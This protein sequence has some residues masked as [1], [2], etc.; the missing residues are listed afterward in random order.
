MMGDMTRKRQQHGF[1]LTETLMAVGTLAIGMTFISGTF[2]AGIYFATLSTERT[3]AAVAAEEGFAKM[4][5]FGLDVADPNLKTAGFVLYDDLAT[6]PAN[7]SLYPSTRADTARQYSWAAICRRVADGNDVVDGNEVA[8]SR[9]LVQCVVFVNRETGGN[10]TYHKRRTG[11][12]GP[13]LETSDLP[14][15]VRV[16]I[17]QD[18]TPAA[19][20][21]ILVKDAVASDAIDERTF[22]NAGSVLVDDGTG[23]IYRV[24]ERSEIDPA[25]I[26][27]DRHWKGSDLTG[28]DGGWVWVIPPPVAGGRIPG[29]AA[30]Q[31]IIRFPRP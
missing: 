2:L 31:K 9:D 23:Q 24:L 8:A 10:S 19:P 11:T 7:E 28:A 29:V 27:L 26:T 30:Y 20:A 22:V 6:L 25:K 21:E 18:A 16:N 1:S 12:N 17:A 3:I 5:I 14:C 15:P 13:Q 4:R